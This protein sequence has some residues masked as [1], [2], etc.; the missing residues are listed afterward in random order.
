M[1]VKSGAEPAYVAYIDE[2]GDD[3]LQRVRPIDHNGSS[4]W[5]MMAAVVIKIDRTEAADG[6]SDEIFRKVRESQPQL[7]ELHF[8]SLSKFNGRL[9]CERVASLP[10][11]GF[12]VSSNKK[13]M[14]RHHNP[15]AEAISSKNWFYCWLTRLLLERVTYFAREKSISEYGTPKPLSIVFGERGRFSYPQLMAYYDWLRMRN[16]NGQNSLPLGDI[17][18]DVMN[19]ELFEVHPNRTRPC[20][21]LADI[22]ASAFFRASDIHQTSKF[23]PECAKLLR[24]RM[25]R[26]PDS[27]TGQ[28][29]GFGVKLMP[30]MGDAR[31]T[32]AQKQIYRFYGYPKPQWWMPKR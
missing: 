10:L 5:L 26:D 7:K 28:L 29:H 11:R 30:K 13:N 32:P 25:A 22:I 23:D 6:W 8:K 19:R 14:R 16:T 27:S 31:L 21:Q 24:P 12:V 9:A 18:W 2:A 15:F 17:S 1:S 3:G 20:L 4:E